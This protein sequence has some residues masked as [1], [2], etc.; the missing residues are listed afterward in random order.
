M[1]GIQR[2]FSDHFN[3][4]Y[5]LPELLISRWLK[6]ASL[7]LF[8][9]LLASLS[10][11]HYARMLKWQYA[12]VKDYQRFPADTARPAPANASA[13]RFA[14]ASPDTA[15][16]LAPTR[17]TLDGEP[18]PFK[19]VLRQT[20]T[21]AFLVIR[22]DT[23][24]YEQYLNGYTASDPVTTFSVAKSW[25]SA[26]VGRA[27]K[28]GHINSVQDPVTRY[29]PTLAD[30]GFDS[31]S[32]RN[33]LNM[34]SGISF[35]ENYRNPFSTVA[36]FYYGRQLDA[37]L[38]DITV[39]RPV[40]DTFIYQ[41]GNTQLL[42]RVLRQATDTTLT[43]YLTEQLWR[44]MGMQH[45]ATWS[46]DQADGTAKAFCCLNARARDF[47]RL[48][49]LYLD[50]GIWEG[51]TLLSRSWIRRSTSPQRADLA[52]DYYYHWW[53]VVDRRLVDS[54]YT[55]ALAPGKRKVVRRRDEQGQL[56]RYVLEPQPD[57]FARGL[58]G[59]YIYVAPQHDLLVLRFGK[60][61]GE[62]PWEVFLRSYA[63]SFR[64]QP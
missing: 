1:Y 18:Q 17:V 10:G 29:C 12:D 53:H 20:N 6:L 49:R 47:A 31:V 59:Q 55:N 36:Q 14:E 32:I 21:T 25:V 44:P 54:N 35:S 64:E 62:F 37:Y 40:G 3:E 43:G 26:L 5:T 63:R 39:E 16:R 30:Q 41:S 34:R 33:L 51:D 48:G 27:V 45:P 28:N 57:L 38:Q 19:Q 61:R 50:E 24:F 9:V 60:D 8:P 2:G 7:F 23:V 52:Y 4:P 15:Q 13:F 46:T 42:A 58:Y 56:Q 11:C 22:Q